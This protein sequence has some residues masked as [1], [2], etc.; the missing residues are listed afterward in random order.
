MPRTARPEVYSHCNRCSAPI[1][2]ADLSFY[3]SE[4]GGY[5]CVPCLTGGPDEPAAVLPPK[6]PLPSNIRVALAHAGR[7]RRGM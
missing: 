5:L 2:T 4:N 7:P 1:T 6:P 3:D